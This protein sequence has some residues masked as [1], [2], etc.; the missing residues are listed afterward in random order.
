MV[1]RESF[2]IEDIPIDSCMGVSHDLILHI[3]H[4]IRIPRAKR[5]PNPIEFLMTKHLLSEVVGV[6][7]DKNFLYLHLLC[8]PI[9]GVFGEFKMALIMGVFQKKTPIANVAIMVL[10]GPIGMKLV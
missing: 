10:Q 1:K 3:S 2:C 7:C 5:L 4:K 9:R 6:F 8:V